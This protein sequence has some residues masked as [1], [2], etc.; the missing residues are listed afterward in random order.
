MT[1]APIVQTAFDAELASLTEPVA[2]PDSP[3]LDYGR[4]LSCVLECDEQ[5]GEVYADGALIIAQAVARRLL[6]PR[7]RVLD[8]ADYGL[9]L[10]ALCNRGM[11]ATELRALHARIVAEAYKDERVERATA[12]LDTDGTVLA[13]ATLTVKLRITPRDPSLEPFDSIIAVSDEQVLIDLLA[14]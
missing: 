11:T 2:A 13:N 4:D 9:D 3:P 14:R 6:T 1:L 10:R 8:D 12:E 5:F 7:G